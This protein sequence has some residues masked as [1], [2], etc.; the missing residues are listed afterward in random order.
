[1]FPGGGARRA[2]TLLY[3]CAAVVG[4][5]ISPAVMWNAADIIV[6]AMT[7]V[8]VVCLLLERRYFRRGEARINHPDL[9]II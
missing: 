5:V 6:G 7:S 2:Y 3:V 1:L 9:P 4:S 8:N